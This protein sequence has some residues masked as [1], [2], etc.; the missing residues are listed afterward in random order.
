MGAEEEVRAGADQRA[1]MERPMQACLVATAALARTPLI[2]VA[3]LVDARPGVVE[4]VVLVVEVPQ[5]CDVAVEAVVLPVLERGVG[6]PTFAVSP[7]QWPKG[8]ESMVA[9]AVTKL[10]PMWRTAKEGLKRPPR[11][12]CHTQ[13]GLQTS[14]SQ[15]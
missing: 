4:I 1:A 6:P 13:R 15:A 9:D 8:V 7:P 14:Q 12:Q 2:V 10:G 11:G 3:C 5:T